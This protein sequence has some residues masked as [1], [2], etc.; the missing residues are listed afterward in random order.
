MSTAADNI[1]LLRERGGVE[2]DHNEFDDNIS[3]IRD[4]L[5]SVLTGIAQTGDRPVAANVTADGTGFTLTWA[6]GLVLGP[7]PL[8]PRPIRRRGA[9]VAG[10]EYAENDMVRQSGLYFATRAHTAGASF[11]DDLADGLWELAVEAGGPGYVDAGPFDPMRSGGYKAGESVTQPNAAD[12][13]L[14]RYVANVAA[15]Q[16]VAP[17]DEPWGLLTGDLDASVTAAI[18]AGEQASQDADLALQQGSTIAANL[19]SVTIDVGALD[20]R[21]SDAELAIEDL[22]DQG[23]DD[24][25]ESDRVIVGFDGIVSNLSAYVLDNEGE[26]LGFASRLDDIEDALDNLEPGG[27]GETGPITLALD[28]L[29]DVDLSTPPTDGQ[30]IVW[31]A[32]SQTYRAATISAGG[33]GGGPITAADVGY[34]GVSGSNVEAALD[35]HETRLV[36]LEA[37]DPTQ[38]IEELSGRMT[39]YDNE[40]VRGK[41]ADTETFKSGMIDVWTSRGFGSFEA[42]MAAVFSRLD[43]LEGG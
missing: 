42:M 38:S 31:H 32:A 10:G 13:K 8:P 37:N 24:N 34:S 11:E 3:V 40:D 4:I 39:T 21:L 5:R 20:N 1:V 26:K 16:G 27:G 28:D 41:V 2:F 22:Q 17:P 19:E 14:R 25:I 15:P 23:G 35:E 18:A 12:G 43:A 9:W 6:S 30:A 33:G 7:I 36:E 29:T